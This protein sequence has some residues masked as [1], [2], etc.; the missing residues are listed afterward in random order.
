MMEKVSTAQKQTKEREVFEQQTVAENLNRQVYDM[1]T[2]RVY[3]L[4]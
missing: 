1:F 2:V 4:M 3:D